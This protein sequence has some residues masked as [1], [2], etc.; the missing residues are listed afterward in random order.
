[1]TI[2]EFILTKFFEFGYMRDQRQQKR[3][4]IIVKDGN[5]RFFYS[6]QECLSKNQ[7]YGRVNLDG[8][9]TLQNNYRYMYH[10]NT[11]TAFT[12]YINDNFIKLRKVEDRTYY[13]RKGY[14]F[15]QTNCLQ[16]TMTEQ[17]LCNILGG[18][19]AEETII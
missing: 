13:R 17:E 3:N 11:A 19:Y 6:D 15:L 1:M 9:L 5:E 16:S 10:W 4:Y 2:V 7:W 8:S 14:N 18:Q 12:N